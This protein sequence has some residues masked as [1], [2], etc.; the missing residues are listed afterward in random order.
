MA[1]D[2]ETK[3]KIRDIADMSKAMMKKNY[4]EVRR[5]CDKV[6]EGE[7]PLQRISIYDDTVL[8]MAAHSK[9]DDLVLDLL[10]MIPEDRNHKLSD[11]KNADGNT[12]L[13]EVAASDAMI[14]A[15][16]ALLER[17]AELLTK[18]NEL[19]EKPIFCAARHGQ[20]DMF[21]FL[22]AEMELEKLSPEESKTH[23]QRD[24]GTTVLHISVATECFGELRY[25]RL[26]CT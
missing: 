3:Q 7:G 4:K 21:L 1:D 22:A 25:I 18:P 26:F 5:L 2:K 16:I 24:D 12:I 11:I 20:T 10:K 9:E 19:G 17:D 13:H 14:C 15:A 8:H 6:P 23:L